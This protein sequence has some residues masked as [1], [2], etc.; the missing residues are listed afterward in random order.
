MQLDKLLDNVQ[1]TANYIYI[2]TTPSVW[3]HILE[4]N[5]LKNP[6]VKMISTGEALPASL[7]KIFIQQ[8][9]SVWN[10]YGPTETTIFATAYN[11]SSDRNL[12]ATASIGK[13]LATTRAYVLNEYLSLTP[14]GVS[15]EL[16]I[17]GTGVM[18]GYIGEAGKSLNQHKLIPN[19]FNKNELLYKTG[20]KVCWLP[21]GNLQFFGRFDDQV[22]IRGF[23][24]DLNQV[25]SVLE[26]SD[27]V[28]KA[29][30]LK[31]DKKMHSASLV[32]YLLLEDE[33]IYPATRK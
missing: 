23:R 31:Q 1:T 29:I 19:P 22:K 4:S 33:N 27:L 32:A 24:V 21:D 17:G 14:I 25:A 9:K 3:S 12:Y 18:Q 11:I 10:C 15:G 2:Q 13:P 26:A 30:V 28:K 7:A 6:S 20:D 8:K 5:L 16:Y